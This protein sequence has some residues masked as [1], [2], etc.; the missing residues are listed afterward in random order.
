MAWPT[1]RVP[2]QDLVSVEGD[3]GEAARFSQRPQS[4]FRPDQEQS[5]KMLDSQ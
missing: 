2:W 4:L 1:K 3:D 5:G